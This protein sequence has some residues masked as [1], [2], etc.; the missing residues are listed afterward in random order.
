MKKFYSDDLYGGF[1]TDTFV[2]IDK[3]FDEMFKPA[4]DN[5]KSDNHKVIVIDSLPELHRLLE[6]DAVKSY[7]QKQTC[8]DG[9]VSEYKSIPI[10]FDIQSI[11]ANHKKNAF[12]VVWGDGSHTIIHLQKGDVWDDE[13]ALAMC[14]VKHMM[15]DTGSFNDIFT[16]EMPEKIK[17][18][19]KAE[20]VEDTSNDETTATSRAIGRFNITKPAEKLIETCERAGIDLKRAG[21]AA[22]GTAKATITLNDS[23]TSMLEKFLS[24]PTPVYDVFVK[25]NRNSKQIMVAA[26]KEVISKYLKMY[27]QKHYPTLIG[28]PWRIWTVGKEHPE[29]YIDFGASEYFVIPGMTCEEWNKNN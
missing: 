20:P 13:K 9:K 27:V 10:C 5:M 15:G 18:I 2:K 16:T 3:M 28:T 8:E 7:E 6:E 12:T 23:L 17:H 22:N 24:N 4:V 29:M 26:E 14:F 1:P 25:G 19:G 21:E 11:T